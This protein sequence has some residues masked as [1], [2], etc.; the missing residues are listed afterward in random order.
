MSGKEARQ[1]LAQTARATKEENLGIREP[2]RKAESQQSNGQGVGSA[3][4]RDA[5]PKQPPAGSAANSTAPPTSA[6]SKPITLRGVI[7]PI[8]ADASGST[9]R[10]NGKGVEYVVFKISHNGSATTLYCRRP[11]MV[12]EIAR[13]QG[14]EAVA[15]VTV[16]TKGNHQY[17]MLDGFAEG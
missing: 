10:R 12:P 1:P 3:S 7:G 13:R 4:T 9:I 6:Q 15:R 17:H 5:K 2:Q 16:V 8:E 11:D 14:R